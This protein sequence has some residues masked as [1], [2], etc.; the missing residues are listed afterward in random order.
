M[1]KKLRNINIATSI[2]WAS[3]IAAAAIVHAPW[4]LTMVLLPMLAF[5]SLA[6]IETISRQP[7][8]AG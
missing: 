4:F 7:S 8:C 6:A 2:L 5:S 3:A 1:K